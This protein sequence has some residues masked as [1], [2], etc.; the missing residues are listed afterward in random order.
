MD[1]W[2]NQPSER[3][4][5]PI[6]A[7]PTVN[8]YVYERSLVASSQDWP[9]NGFMPEAAGCSHG[10]VDGGHVTD[11]QATGSGVGHREAG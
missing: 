7:G 5:R 9:A 11:H 3:R 8:E 1:G 4:H 10:E 6:V 2:P